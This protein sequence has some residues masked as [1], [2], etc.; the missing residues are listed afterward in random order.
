MSLFSLL[1]RRDEQMLDQ[2][3][4]EI[5]RRCRSDVQQHLSIAAHAMTQNEVQ[6]YVRS[7]AA[8]LLRREASAALS[9]RGKLDQNTRR[10]LVTRAT[11]YVV[12]L[13]LRQLPMTTSPTSSRRAG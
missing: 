11:D 8:M 1:F 13:V 4:Q 5:A 7:R 9:R 2:M 3:A 12:P 10:R 6:G